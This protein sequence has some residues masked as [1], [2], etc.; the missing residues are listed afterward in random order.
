MELDIVRRSFEEGN[1]QGL[2]LAKHLGVVVLGYNGDRVARGFA[3]PGA[4]VV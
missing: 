3:A 1:C 2:Y 4:A